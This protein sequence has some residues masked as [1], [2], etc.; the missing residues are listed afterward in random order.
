MRKRLL[1]LVLLLV[2]IP[3]WTFSMDF[4]PSEQWQEYKTVDGIRIDYRMKECTINGRNQN[5]LLFKFTNLTNDV[6][7][8]SWVTEIWRNDVCVNC[9][10][11][12]DSENAHYLILAPGQSVEGSET[13]KDN[14]ALYIFG[15]FVQQVPGMSNHYLT[16]FE[17]QQM[18][19]D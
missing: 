1:T 11:L 9:Q 5:L 16:G 13:S 17:L 7:N 2:S 19:I 12:T 10:S 15:N 14:K 6:K 18:T 3:L 4:E 8:C